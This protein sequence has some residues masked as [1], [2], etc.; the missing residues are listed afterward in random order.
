[1]NWLMLP[2][3]TSPT[4][5][6][7]LLALMQNFYCC[8]QALIA[9]FR[10]FFMV[11]QQGFVLSVFPALSRAKGPLSQAQL[12]YFAAADRTRGHQRDALPASQARRQ[13]SLSTQSGNSKAR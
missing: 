4:F 12:R 11:R 5:A 2:I 1:M 9:I 3:F 10:K 7:A 6:M 13:K 8:S